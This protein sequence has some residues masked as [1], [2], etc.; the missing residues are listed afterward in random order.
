[1]KIKSLTVCVPQPR[2]A[3]PEVALRRRL[4]AAG[5][6]TELRRRLAKARP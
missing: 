5:S 1:M 6:M 4:A 2:Q 3:P